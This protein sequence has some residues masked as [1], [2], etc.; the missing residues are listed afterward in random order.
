[1]G[2]DEPNPFL[3]FRLGRRNFFGKRF[4][5][6][7]VVGGGGE[8]GGGG[9]TPRRWRRRRRRKGDEEIGIF[10]AADCTIRDSKWKIL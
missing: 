8:G 9:P 3:G 4:R 1:M 6:E 7:G 2:L 10:L 5:I